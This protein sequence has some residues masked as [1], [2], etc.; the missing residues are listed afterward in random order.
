MTAFHA[1][2]QC[3]R[4]VEVKKRVA[5]TQKER[6]FTRKSIQ[7]A[8][9]ATAIYL[10]LSYFLIGFKADQ[11]VL[12]GIFNT[13]Y[14]AGWSTRNFILGLSIFIIYWIIFDYM[15]A[16]PNYKF[17]TVHIQDLYNW[18]KNWFGFNWKNTIVTPNEFFAQN[19]STFMDVLGGLFYLCWI[20]LP[21]AFAAAMFFRNRNIFSSFHLHFSL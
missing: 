16:F 7:V 15:K 12:V 6:L 11:L 9:G 21:L 5:I 17:N 8:I 14:F 10:V 4:K 2:K 3:H 18:E 20:P 1:N 19:N 13:L